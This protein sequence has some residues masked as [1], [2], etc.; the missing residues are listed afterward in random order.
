MR[1][2]FPKAMSFGKRSTVENY[3][4]LGRHVAI[5]FGV[6]RQCMATNLSLFPYVELMCGATASNAHLA[7]FSAVGINGTMT[8]RCSD[9]IIL[10]ACLPSSSPSN[11]TKAWSMTSWTC[12][13]RTELM[14]EKSINIPSSDTPSTVTT[15]PSISASNR[16]RCPCKCLHFDL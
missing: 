4:N 2:N 8:V 13:M 10:H 3:D 14:S 7:R 15:S 1:W 16:Y 9:P 12:S 11:T 6:S 5:D